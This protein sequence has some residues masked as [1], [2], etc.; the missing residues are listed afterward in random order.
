[1]ELEQRVA[2]DPQDVASRYDLASAYA[3]NQD[4]ARA[5]DNFLQVVKADRQLHDDGAR[6]ALLQLLDVVDDAELVKQY[7]SRLA[8]TLY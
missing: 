5:M 7:R 8:A 4:Y 2:D 6:K 3:A 1:M